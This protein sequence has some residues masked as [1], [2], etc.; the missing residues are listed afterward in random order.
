MNRT[1]LLMG[2]TTVNKDERQKARMK[3]KKQLLDVPILFLILLQE[4]LPSHKQKK[5][6]GRITR[7]WAPSPIF[8]A[9]Y[10]IF[11]IL[12]LKFYKSPP[13]FYVSHLIF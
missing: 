12:H 9:S 4:P 2:K 8:Y 5:T 13:K 7:F 11:Y 6:V 10:L 3:G 1:H